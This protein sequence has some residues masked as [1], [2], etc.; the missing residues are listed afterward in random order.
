MNDKEIPLSST[1]YQG[2]NFKHEPEDEVNILDLLTVLFRKRVLISFTASIIIALS[3]FYAFSTKNTYRATIWFQLSK[4][5]LTNTFPEAY[6]EVIRNASQSVVGK[7]VKNLV[8]EKKLLFNK[9]IAELQSYSNQEKVFIEGKFHERFVAD[10]PKNDMKKGIVQEIYRSIHTRKGVG[11]STKVV[12]FEMKGVN[13]E[14]A[15][16]YLNALA[17]WVKIKIEL[18]LQKSIEKGAKAQ[19]AAYSFQLNS[20]IIKAQKKHEDKV[21]FLKDNIE[22]AKNLG[23]SGNNFDKYI[24]GEH[25]ELSEDRLTY[26]YLGLISWPAWYLYGQRAL[27]QQLNLMERRGV[28]SQSNKETS[29]L[30]FKIESISKQD[31]SKINFEPVII[32]RPSIPPV[33]QIND[34][35][36]S[37]IL[38]GTLSGLIIGILIALLGCLMTELKKRSKLPPTKFM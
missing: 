3:I 5:S 19:L 22:I 29:E 7:N 14:L 15:S 21:I 27:E 34:T 31:F 1:P 38:I 20:M 2:E 6:Q 12:D 32:S 25:R 28:P 18:D 23:I 9:F 8:I 11:L 24:P 16:D 26:K 4:K 10:N 35:K 17:D 36:M 33:D 30:I 13:P 37:I